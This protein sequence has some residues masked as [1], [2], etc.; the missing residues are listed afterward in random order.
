MPTV[1]YTTYLGY[2][3]SEAN[4]DELLDNQHR[5]R[6][7]SLFP[8]LAQHT[9]K[10]PPIYTMKC[11]EYKGLPSAYLIYLSSIDEYDAATKL[12]GSMRHWRKLLACKWFMEG[13]KNKGFEGLTLWRED[14]AARDRSSAKKALILKT[15]DG[16]TSAARKILDMSKVVATTPAIGRPNTK[17]DKEQQAKD[18]K[19]A[20]R[21][22]RIEKLKE[23]DIHAASA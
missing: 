2:Q 5:M 1:D 15:V 12:V 19:A 6:T 23:V 9:D 16:D 18:D 22:K 21:L 13:L 3:A 20:D 8:E 10:Y 7:A 17:A 14:M 4:R 11:T